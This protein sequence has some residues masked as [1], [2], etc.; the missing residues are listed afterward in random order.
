MEKVYKSHEMAYIKLKKNGAI[1]WNEM[2]DKSHN[3]GDHIGK[4][5][6]IYI[7]EILNNEWAPKNGKVLEIGCGTGHLINW[8]SSFGYDSFGIE[9]SKTAY[10]M[11]Q[12]LFNN[13]NLHFIN[14][15][16]CY[17]NDLLEN[18]YDIIID[19]HCFHCIV[20]KCDRMLFLENVYKYLKKSGIFIL[21]TMAKPVNIERFEKENKTHKFIN[22]TLYV[23]C[24]KEFE[25]SIIID[26]KLYMAQRKIEDFQT[27][28]TQIR[29]KFLIKNMKY[30]YD[31]LTGYIMI[32]CIK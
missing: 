2:Y 30:V 10:N 20:E 4:D 31:D 12:E 9:I 25:G 3:A 19:G 29:N 6:Q 16:F 13:K 23:A 7:K 26:G 1:S 11:A 24:E 8:L 14:G 17:D 32:A 18:D 5:R 15:D 27:I 22:D 21:L 28:I